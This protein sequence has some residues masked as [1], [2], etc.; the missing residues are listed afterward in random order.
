MN[1]LEVGDII[2]FEM[3]VAGSIW[4]I[5]DFVAEVC[6][7]GYIISVTAAAAISESISESIWTSTPVPSMWKNP[8]KWAPSLNSV[9]KLTDL[10]KIAFNL[11][12]NFQDE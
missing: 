5:W 2:E 11:E 3:T 7:G 9:R 6:D 8:I 10:E 4:R 12:K 1:E